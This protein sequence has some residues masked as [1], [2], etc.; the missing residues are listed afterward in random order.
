VD[1]DSQAAVVHASQ[2][3]SGLGLVSA[4]G[5]VS[6]RI[7]GRMLITPAADLA[8][9]GVA[10]LIEADLTATTLP[11]GAPAEAWAHLRVYAARPDVAAIARAQP[12][13][14]FAVSAVTPYLPPVYGQACWLGPGV[15]PVHDGARLLRSAG[16]ADDAARTLGR[17]DALLL[18]GNG[19]ITCGATPEQAVTRMWLLAAACEAWLAAMPCGTVRA[20]DDGE[21]ESW[22]AVQAELLPRLWPH[23]LRRA[24][25]PGTGRH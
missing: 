11:P 21:I 4:F 10:D 2:V 9:V 22:R 1:P 7:A 14:A 20:M 25:L 15:I 13:A 6:R 3:L 19:A 17:S 18:R 16:L 5:H 24:G 8:T 23:L 12:P